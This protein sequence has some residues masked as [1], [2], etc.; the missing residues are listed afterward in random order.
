MTSQLPITA[1][2]SLNHFI[3]LSDDSSKSKKKYTRAKGMTTGFLNKLRSAITYRRSAAR[4]LFATELFGTSQC[5]SIDEETLYHGTKS[6]ILK[7]FETTQPMQPQSKSVIL[8]E[9]SPLL[10]R[11]FN[12]DTF[13]TYAQRLYYF[14]LDMGRDYDRIDIIC[15]R[16]IENSLKSQTRVDRGKGSY[17]KFDDKTQFPKDFK[18]NFLKSSKNKSSLNLYLAEKFYDF[19]KEDK[20]LVVTKNDGILTN[21]NDLQNEKSLTSCSAEEADQKIIRHMIHCISSDYSHVQIQTIDTDVFILALAFRHAAN[22]PFCQVIV[23]LSLPKCKRFYD[24]TSYSKVLGNKVCQGLPFFHAFSG[25][26]SLSSFYNHGKCKLWDK[27]EEFPESELL[28]STFIQLSTKPMT[29][30]NDNVDI[31]EKYISYV[32][33]SEYN[34][35]LDELRMKDFEFSVHDSFRLHPP[36]RSGLV[37]HIKRAAIQAGW[38]DYQCKENTV[39]PDPSK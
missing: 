17:L 39:L 18:D 36:S 1:K 34:S 24:V 27:W 14:I 8:I 30:S 20:I 7:R 25:C 15:E 33:F 11:N 12:A 28:T 35:C 10:R 6:D 26:D 22:N 9:L 5:F 16:Y 32:Y 19:H 29:I 2:I 23:C 21:I 3:L 37:Q 31:L 38:V 13:L 4:Q